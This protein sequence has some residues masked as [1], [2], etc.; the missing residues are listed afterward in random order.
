MRAIGRLTKRCVSSEKAK[1][2]LRGAR[3]KFFG[4]D[5]DAGNGSGD[6]LEILSPSKDLITECDST[7]DTGDWNNMSIVIRLTMGQ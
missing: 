3:C 5:D 1:Y 4:A 7:D 6:D 2:F